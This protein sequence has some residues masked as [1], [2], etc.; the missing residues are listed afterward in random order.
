[1]SN[2]DKSE[3]KRTIAECSVVEP[4]RYDTY[5]V[6]I[7]GVETS[8]Y[9]IDSSLP[10]AV[11]LRQLFDA[12]CKEHGD[13]VSRSSHDFMHMLFH[14]KEDT[15]FHFIDIQDEEREPVCKKILSRID[16]LFARAKNALE[17]VKLDVG[18]CKF[19]KIDWPMDRF[20]YA[21]LDY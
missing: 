11:A 6:E 3:K 20:F 14:H 2:Q 17:T 16:K 13:N 4:T 9:R 1:M 21:R 10:S 19:F 8:C 7:D 5:V 18:D 15:P 12:V